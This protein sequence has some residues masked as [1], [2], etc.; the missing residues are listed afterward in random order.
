[1]AE[2]ARKIQAIFRRKR[3]SSENT[4]LGFKIS[5]PSVIS[6]IS[7]LKIPVTLSS[8]FE[9]APVGFTEVAGYLTLRSKPRIRYVKGRGW[10][11]EGAEHVKYVAAKHGKTTVVFQSSQIQISG[12]ANYEEIYRLCIKNKWVPAATIRMTPTINNINGKFKVNKSIDLPVF[13]NY[14]VHN[15][16]EGMLEEKPKEILPE[17]RAPALTVKFAKPKITFQFFSNGT[18]LFSSKYVDIPPE[19]FKQFFTKYKFYADEVFGSYASTRAMNRNPSAGTWDKLISP[20]PRGWYIRPGPDGQ[21]RLYPY[22][23]YRKLEQGPTILNGTVDLGPLATKVRKAFEAA[24]Q[25]IPESTM[26]IFR[27]AGAP[28]NVASNKTE[29]SGPAA[30]RASSWNAVKNGYYVRP[31]AGGQ[32]Y[33]YA[34]PKGIA[35]GRKTVISTYTKAGRNI[36]KAVR[37]IFKI[38]NNVKI[39]NSKKFHNFTKEKNG[40]LKINGKQATRLTK[41]ELIAIARNANIAQVNAKMKPANIIAHIKSKAFPLNIKMPAPPK[42]PSPQGSVSSEGNNNFALELNYQ[43]KIRQNL[44][45]NLYHNGNEAEFMKIYKSLPTGA[46]GKPLKADINS[47]YKRFI[48]NQYLFRGREFPKKPRAPKN[49]TLNYVYNIPK[50]SANFSN[51]LEIAGL[52][53]KKNWTWNE[54]RAAVKGKMTDAQLK[55]LKAKWNSNVVAKAPPTGAVGR[56]KRKVKRT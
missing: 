29:Y 49:Q 1:M 14:I 41:A 24:G 23:Y 2:A 30:R 38:S 13:R 37:E 42:K 19:L 20:V 35:A 56:L 11:G 53:S 12:P 32:P 45:N 3:N 6:T 34:I 36:P 55:K 7:T 54:I 48:K 9:S 27:N 16:P 28:L 43:Y 25:P 26:R 15:I 10:I 51:A 31:G 44:G 5:K 4:G 39:N 33:F 40:S 50:N 46:R 21:P 17:V 22:E 52:N 8:I 47:A 18:I